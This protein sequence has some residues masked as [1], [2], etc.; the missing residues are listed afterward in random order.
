MQALSSKLCSQI[1]QTT[2]IQRALRRPGSETR[3][4]SLDEGL[5]V[6]IQGVSLLRG[7]VKL[8]QLKPACGLLP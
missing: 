3:Y 7:S 2:D 6:V 4:I 5:N 1:L 8:H